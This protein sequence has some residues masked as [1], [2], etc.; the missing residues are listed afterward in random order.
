MMVMRG[1]VPDRMTWDKGSIIV[2][3]ASSL[4]ELVDHASLPRPPGFLDSSWCS[5]S[6]TPITQDDVAVWPYSVYILLEFTS[7]LA[8]LHCFHGAADLGKY[9]ISH[10]ELLLMLELNSGHRLTCE[11]VI[12]HHLRA[13]SPWL[14]RVPRPALVTRS[15][16]VASLWV[17]SLVD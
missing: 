13:R 14:V 17:I 12:R 15:V 2:P 4:R 10:L 1:T 7:F 8:T 11:K 3:R 9:G 5:L 16:E 6:L